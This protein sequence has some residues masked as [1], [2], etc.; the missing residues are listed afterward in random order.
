LPI[1]HFELCKKQQHSRIKGLFRAYG[2]AES[3]PDFQ[4]GWSDCMY[5]FLSVFVSV[6]HLEFPYGVDEIKKI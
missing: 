5:F 3:P 4:A 1:T 6:A 2:V